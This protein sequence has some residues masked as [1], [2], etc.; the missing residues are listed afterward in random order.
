MS[1]FLSV[2]GYFREVPLKISVGRIRV[3]IFVSQ[4][5]PLQ[6]EWNPL[7]LPKGPGHFRLVYKLLILLRL[8][9]FAHTQYKDRLS[10]PIRLPD[11]GVLLTT[12]TRISPSR[13]HRTDSGLL[14][15]STR[16]PK[17]RLYEPTKISLCGGGSTGTW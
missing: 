3:P 16:I 15:P 13:S 2:T 10:S 11:V 6:L 7:E 14:Q 12:P 9:L 4:R 1:V 17:G 8:I 5:L